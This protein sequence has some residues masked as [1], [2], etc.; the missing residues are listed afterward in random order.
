MTASAVACIGAETEGHFAMSVHFSHR[1]VPFIKLF[2]ILLGPIM[3][4]DQV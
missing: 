3:L 4:T 1:Q 2:G